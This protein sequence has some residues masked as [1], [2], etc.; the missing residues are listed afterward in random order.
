VSALTKKSSGVVPAV[1]TRVI[2]RVWP[3]EFVTVTACAAPAVPCAWV[4]KLTL[5]G[6]N[7]TY[8]VVSSSTDTS[9]ES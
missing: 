4:P 3:L 5:A 1:E 9:F 6:V 8:G 2:V 7:V